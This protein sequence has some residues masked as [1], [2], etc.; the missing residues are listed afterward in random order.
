MKLT[1]H[2]QRGFSLLELL[3]VAALTVLLALLIG[4]LFQKGQYLF[5]VDAAQSSIQRNARRALQSV[6]VALR[7]ARRSTITIPASPNNNQITLDLPIFL[8]GATCSAFADVASGTPP[9]TCSSGIDCDGQC[10]STPGTNLCANDICRRTYTY[11]ISAAN[12]ISQLIVSTPSEAD[13]IVG[14]H[15]QTVLFRNNTMNVNLNADE[16]EIGLTAQK[17]TTTE[18]RTHSLTLSNIVQVRN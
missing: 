5:D 6:T 2:D 10:N 9:Q 17:A 13:R 12:G 8:S 15:I 4:V 14:N 3:F 18:N 1:K 11:S 16:I 7:K